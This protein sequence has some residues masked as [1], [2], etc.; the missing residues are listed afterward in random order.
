MFTR[1]EARAICDRVLSLA[2]ADETLVTLSS[3]TSDNLRFAR[4]TA[5]TSGSADTP[6]LAISSTFGSRTGTFTI[7]QFDDRSLA[8]AVRRAEDIAR[9]APEDPEHM[10]VLGPQS[11]L[12]KVTVSVLKILILAAKVIGPQ[13]PF[14]RM[15]LQRHGQSGFSSDC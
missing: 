1:K 10:P 6:S 11:R 13:A 3:G 8:E 2:T 9:L 14:L 12:V 7:N 4:N 15:G 5:S